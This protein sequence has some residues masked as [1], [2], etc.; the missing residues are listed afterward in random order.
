VFSLGAKN[1][2]PWMTLKG[3]DAFCSHSV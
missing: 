2:R 3:R 1:Q